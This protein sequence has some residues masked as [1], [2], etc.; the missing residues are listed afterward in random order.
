MPREYKLYLQD[1][2][3]AIGRIEVYI[4][5][6]SAEDIMSGGMSADAVLYNLMVIGEAAKHVPEDVRER[7]SNIEWRNIGRLRDFV[8]HEY[9]GI[10]L[11]IISDVLE[12]ELPKLRHSIESMLEQEPPS[13]RGPSSH[14]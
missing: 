8:A 4:G 13:S 7:Q 1:I 12:N 2:L 6:A 3:D 9:F 5:E 10:D 11:E 14:S